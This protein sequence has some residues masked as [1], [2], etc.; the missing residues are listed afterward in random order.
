MYK[1]SSTCTSDYANGNMFTEYFI[2]ANCS[3]FFAY[4]N[5]YSWM[6]IVTVGYSVTIVVQA[7]FAVF[8]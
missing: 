2:F 8:K 7:V 5:T 1:T 6:V 3:V 4:E